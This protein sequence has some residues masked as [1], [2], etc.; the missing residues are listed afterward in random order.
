MGM[1]FTVPHDAEQGAT[2]QTKVL[3]FTVRLADKKPF[4]LHGGRESHF[5]KSCFIKDALGLSLQYQLLGEGRDVSALDGLGRGY[6]EVRTC[7]GLI[8][9]ES[10]K[11]SYH[12]ADKDLILHCK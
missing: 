11:L 3:M 12:N 10:W 9:E 7:H 1:C 5:A 8:Q 6:M 2:S 4:F